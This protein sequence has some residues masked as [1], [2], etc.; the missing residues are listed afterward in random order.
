MKNGGK[1]HVREQWREACQR[2]PRLVCGGERDDGLGSLPAHSIRGRTARQIRGQAVLEAGR[3]RHK[4]SQQAKQAKVVPDPQHAD[5]T[6][7]SPCLSSRSRWS[8][9]GALEGSLLGKKDVRPADVWVKRRPISGL[10]VIAKALD[11]CS[12][13]I[14]GRHDGGVVVRRKGMRCLGDLKDEAGKRGAVL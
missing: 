5:R 3:A 7:V 8:I 14:I 9:L 6:S 12:V 4:W 10:T 13:E 1:Y 2:V 11:E